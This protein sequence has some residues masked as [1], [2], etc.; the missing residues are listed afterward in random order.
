MVEIG[1]FCAFNDQNKKIPHARRGQLPPL[2]TPMLSGLFSAS[3]SLSGATLT[4]SGGGLPEDFTFEQLHFHWGA[5]DTTG[6]EHTLDGAQYPL[7]V[8][9]QTS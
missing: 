8:C 1:V 3:L 2:P 9:F 6:S 5:S 7:E 4:L